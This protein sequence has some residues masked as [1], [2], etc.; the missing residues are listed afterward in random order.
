MHSNRTAHLTDE[1]L[2]R[3]Q[4]GELPSA[5]AAH[6]EHCP[7]CA[8]RL[9]DWNAAAAAYAEYRDAIRAPLLS[10]APQPWRSLD[11]L[12]AAHQSSRGTNA[13]RWWAVAMAAALS[14]ALALVATHRSA[15]QPSARANRLLAR[16]ALATLPAN[17]MIAMRA[18]GRTL[19][20]PAVLA[21]DEGD[22]AADPDM[23][24]LRNLF[25][26]ARYGWREPLSPRTFQSW[27]NMQKDRRD[28]V[29]MIS[30][31]GE[32][33]LYR[34]R[35]DVPAGV[36]RTASLLLRAEDLRPT[37]GDFEFAGEGPVSITETA[38]PVEAAPM[39]RPTTPEASP[40]ETPVGPADTLRVLAALNEIGA[41]A[42]EPLDVSQDARHR[43]VVVR[44]AGLDPA[45]QQQ[46]AAAL[47]P[48]PR[49]TLDFES[50]PPRTAAV[51][52]AA[53]Q[54]YSSNI[55]AG[56]RQRF[57]ERL[58]GPVA[59]QELTDRTLEA[60][61]VI[62]ARAHAMEVLAANF[63]PETEARLSLQDRSLLRRLRLR[64]VA[65]LERLAARIR[66]GLKPL[67]ASPSAPHPP[68]GD[69]QGGE[70]WQAGVS[71]LVAS[72]RE[73][74]RVL[75]QILAGSYSQSSAEDLLRGLASAVDRLES[76][77]QSQSKGE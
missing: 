61:A 21:S 64:H 50:G 54:T 46:I 31:R 41:D 25:R 55:P 5:G 36:L 37:A 73:T 16:S 27:R 29:S 35:T 68:F 7:V 1:Q 32:N 62:L 47:A 15:D 52:L 3:F 60:S 14:L 63:P 57:E 39:A 40:V 65:E 4:D 70:T 69:N 23:A 9:R 71:S 12:I 48:L 24:H 13:L 28:S 58:G 38:A 2:A 77:V 34:V 18:R 42:G 75:N 22:A 11:Q 74:D 72:A 19:L 6:L 33:R 53:P 67:L 10:P 20:R 59:V 30:E 45:R 76:A 43:R 51:S 8:S 26:S 56:L 66:T 49:V 44:A 17:R